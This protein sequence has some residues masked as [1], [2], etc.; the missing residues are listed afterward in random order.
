M[1]NDYL[2]KSL[3]TP[4]KIL[5][6]IP[7]ELV[8]YFL[9][10][11][12]DGDGCFYYNRENY[13]RQF[14]ISGTYNQDWNLFVEIFNKIGVEKY[15]IENYKKKS[16]YSQIKITNKKDIK[17]IGDFIYSSIQEDNI[18]LNRKY[19]KYKDLII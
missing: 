5:S 1:E 15:K 18:G 4:N 6:N 16:E 11:I 7:N 9:L 2:E 8:K 12:I 3:K 10:G 19:K 13:L 17:I 14:V